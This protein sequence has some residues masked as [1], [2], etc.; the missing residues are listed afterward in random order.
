MNQATLTSFE[1]E[2]TKIAGIGELWHKLRGLFGQPPKGKKEPEKTKT[3]L[4]V[5]Y[6]FSPKAGDDKWDKFVK[7][8]R[9]PKFVEAIAHHPLSDKKLIQHT[10]AMHRMA[11]G[12]TVGKIQSSRLPGRSYEIKKTSDGLACTCPDWRFKGSVN[13]GYECKH[14]RAHHAGK[15]KA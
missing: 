14:I 13:L 3:D 2:L 4:M 5:D 15:A 11:R 1:D 9:D 12:S 8:V 10:R 7:N 6:H